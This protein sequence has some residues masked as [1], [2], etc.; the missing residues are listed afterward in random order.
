MRPTGEGGLA[1]TTH[2]RLGGQGKERVD[3]PA[4]AEVEAKPSEGNRPG[5]EG[6]LEERLIRGRGE[7]HDRPATGCVAPLKGRP[8]FGPAHA[9]TF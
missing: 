2:D 4:E 8:C 5:K 7:T 6:V 1:T 9:A 3:A